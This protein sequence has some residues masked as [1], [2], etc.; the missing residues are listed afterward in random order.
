M[1]GTEPFARAALCLEVFRELGLVSLRRSDDAL[2]LVMT[3]RGKKVSLEQSAYLRM[4]QDILEMP[5]RGGTR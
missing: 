1:G 4:L 5:K 3:D 2:R